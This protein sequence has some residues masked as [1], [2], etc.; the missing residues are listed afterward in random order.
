ME[1]ERILFLC[2]HNAARSQIAEGLFQDLYGDLFD[3]CSAGTEPRTVHPLAIKCMEEIG[4]DI[5]H[6]RSKSLNEFQDHEFDYVIT[7]CENACPLF[8]GGKKYFKQSFED[9]SA[10]EGTEEEKLNFFIK[11]R[12]DLKDWLE[13]LYYSEMRL[14]DE[15]FSSGYKDATN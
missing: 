8:F 7:V 14:E 1:K 9:P 10:L 4:I 6:H 12:D 13:D 3:V 2:T 11:I 15:N 5:S